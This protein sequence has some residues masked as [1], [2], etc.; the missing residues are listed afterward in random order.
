MLAVALVCSQ[1]TIQTASAESKSQKISRLTDKYC[2]KDIARLDAFH[3]NVKNLLGQKELEPVKTQI[4]SILEAIEDMIGLNQDYCHLIKDRRPPLLAAGVRVSKSSNLKL[5]NEEI[6]TETLPRLKMISRYKTNVIL[7]ID[8]SMP[9]KANEASS[10]RIVD[11]SKQSLQSF[12]I[13]IE[14]Q[15]MAIE[16]YCH[17]NQISSSKSQRLRALK[18][19][20]E[21]ELTVPEMLMIYRA[22]D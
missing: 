9:P 12:A 8:E 10:N 5:L 2:Q 15:E 22:E 20:M 4:E 17:L 21:A 3:A 11:A 6:C 18:A 13:A 14:E 16:T 19:G 7:A 1:A